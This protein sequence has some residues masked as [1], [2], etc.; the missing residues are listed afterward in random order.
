LIMRIVPSVSLALPAL[1]LLA[2]CVESTT[3]PPPTQVIVQ[4][5][6]AITPV[7]PMPPPP[8][9]A[10]L[11]PPP[12]PGTSPTVWQPGHWRYTGIAGSPWTWESGQYVAVPA[13]ASA[14]VPGQWQQQGAGFVWREGHWA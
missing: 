4:P 9:Q 2:G 3:S 8:S 1:V 10:E 5:Q 13:G 14:W 6:A 11:V 7:A 12:P